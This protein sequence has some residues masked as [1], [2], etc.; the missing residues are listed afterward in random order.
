MVAL[1]HAPIVD[2]SSACDCMAPWPARGMP[3]ACTTWMTNQC[4]VDPSIDYCA[5]GAD[6]MTLFI[7]ALENF[8]T[9]CG[10]EYVTASNY[11]LV[12][13]ADFLSLDRG[14]VALHFMLSGI[15]YGLN[16]AT[17]P[18]FDLILYNN[19]IYGRRALY[20]SAE[21]FRAIGLTDIIMPDIPL[22]KAKF[23]ARART[24]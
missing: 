8:A 21:D 23:V 13:K 6:F 22:R 19:D 14:G 24:G 16:D 1:Y 17:N 9:G 3:T 11:D 18:N 12:I 15:S 5:Y 7:A 2:A 20:G 10:K 4:T